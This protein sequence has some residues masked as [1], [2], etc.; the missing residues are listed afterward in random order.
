M[1]HQWLCSV[2]PSNHRSVMGKEAISQRSNQ[3]ANANSERGWRDLDLRWENLFAGKPL[4]RHS[5]MGYGTATSPM[6]SHMK[7]SKKHVGN[8]KR[9]FD[10]GTNRY[11]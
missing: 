11:V 2:R 5:V 1:V 7:A 8:S 4:H 6:K 3:E 10:Y 9:F